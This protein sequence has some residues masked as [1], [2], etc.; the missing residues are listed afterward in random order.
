MFVRL[1]TMMA[2]VAGLALA[3]A[4]VVA[5]QE[6]R[7]DAAPGDVDTTFVPIT[8][9]RLIDTRPGDSR[10]GSGG[11]FGPG[12][13]RTL[14]AR[15]T[16]GNCTIP[17]AA[18]GLSLN[19]T[20][21]KASRLTFLTIWPGGA[22]P[23]ASSLNPAPGEPPTPNAVSTPLSGNGSFRIYNDVGTVEVIV[24][25]TGYYQRGSLQQLAGA[26]AANAKR[27]DDLERLVHRLV[28]GQVAETGQFG[29]SGGSNTKEVVGIRV[30]FRTCD[31]NKLTCLD[32]TSRTFGNDDRGVISRFGAGT[33][34]FAAI[35]ESL[36]NGKPNVLEVEARTV[37]AD[38]SLGG[39]GSS[40]GFES[41]FFGRDPVSGSL[42]HVDLQGLPIGSIA[43]VMDEISVYYNAPNWTY[44]YK[45]RVVLELP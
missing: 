7:V 43:I 20:A 36:T 29:G 10:V 27:V 6:W 12:E 3:L 30:W 39:G 32:L 16:N 42:D 25:V 41:Y 14:A 35:V 8:P 26:S 21:L 15:G 23:D 37:Y 31:A 18:T 22:L 33:P 45:Y 44:S 13:T 5:L 4:G 34:G 11:A 24:D 17:A 28:G 2:F 19:V 9:C 38:R 1:H 40:S